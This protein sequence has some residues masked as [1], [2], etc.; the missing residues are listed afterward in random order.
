MVN[1]LQAE[2]T[3]ESVKDRFKR[4]VCVDEVVNRLNDCLY[5]GLEYIL[6]N[7]LR[8]LGLRGL[9]GN[10][11]GRRLLA[12]V[13]LIGWCVER[14]RLYRVGVLDVVV[15]VVVVVVRLCVCA[16]IIA[17]TRIPR[18]RLHTEVRAGRVTHFVRLR[19]FYIASVK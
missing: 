12:A 8:L 7:S 3:F 14:F 16:I 18:R 19:S 15:V 1:S 5:D 11:N 6:Q 9:L 4:V 13:Q 17:E 2:Y 10:N